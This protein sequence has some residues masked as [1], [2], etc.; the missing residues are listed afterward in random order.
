M[1]RNRTQLQALSRLSQKAA[2]LADEVGEEAM[3]L[4]L[5]IVDDSAAIRKILER[6]L[7]QAG[8]PVG[9][10]FH[11]GDGLEALDSLKSH[12]VGLV[13][14]DINMPNMD[15]LELLG[16]LKAAPEWQNIPV[17]MVTTESGQTKVMQAVELGAAGYIRKPFTADQIKA[18]LEGFF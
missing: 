15:G 11:A 17:I 9:N 5:L 14:A 10:V 4:D 12:P 18:K 3:S 7:R 8:V 16:R 13:L 1:P 6:V 2:A